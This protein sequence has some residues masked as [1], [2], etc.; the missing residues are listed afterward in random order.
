[1][2]DIDTE[3]EAKIL[4]HFSDALREMA[5]SIVGLEDGYFRALHEVITE[6][7]K[8]M[9]DVSRIDVHYMSQ[10]VTIMS[11]WQEAVQTAASHMESLDTMDTTMYLVHHEDA[12]RATKEYVA[13]VL[14]AREERKAAQ[15]M[16]KAAWK[17]AM[18]TDDLQ[19]PVVC[20]LHVTHKAACAQCNQAVD[21]FLDS[22]KDTLKKHVPIH[23]QGPLI[24]NALSTAFQF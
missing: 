13:A 17:E 1:M 18:K 15:A 6:T 4:G 21:A 16:E 19:D 11:A 20:L 10:V 14:K 23:A 2:R 22:I 9:C 5:T 7:E 12:R 3:D 24:S 8:A